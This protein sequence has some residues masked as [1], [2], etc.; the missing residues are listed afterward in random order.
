MSITHFVDGQWNALCDRCGF[1]Y[2]A[3]KLRLEWTGLR[4]CNECFEP[5]HPQTLIK[6]PQEKINTSWAR[7]DPDMSYYTVNWTAVAAAMGGAPFTVLAPA[8]T[9]MRPRKLGDVNNDGLVNATD[10]TAI[11][12]YAAGGALNT[13]AINA[14]CSWLEQYLIANPTTYAAYVT[15]NNYSS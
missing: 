13:Q 5:R 3:D 7:P 6:V 9:V 12:R 14:Y 11:N 2:K 15:L 10:T 1:K 4:V 8:D